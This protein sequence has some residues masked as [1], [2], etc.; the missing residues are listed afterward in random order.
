MFGQFSIEREFCEDDARDAG[1]AS[2]MATRDVGSMVGLQPRRT[3]WIEQA[4]RVV[5][6]SFRDLFLLK[7]VLAAE[8]MAQQVGCCGLGSGECPNNGTYENTCMYVV[9]VYG[10]CTYT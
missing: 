8:E 6:H 2:A 3:Q 4:G 5:H 9:H 10:M 7:Q 1:E